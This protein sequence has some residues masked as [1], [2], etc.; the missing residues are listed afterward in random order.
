[1]ELRELFTLHVEALNHSHTAEE[2]HKHHAADRSYDDE[3]TAHVASLTGLEYA[4]DT[5]DH[6]VL[7]S[8]VDDTDLGTHQ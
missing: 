6:S 4:V 5:S 8:R 7:F 3:I 1:M 2:L